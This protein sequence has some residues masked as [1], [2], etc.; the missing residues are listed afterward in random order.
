MA[1]LAVCVACSPTDQAD[2]DKNLAAPDSTGATQSMAGGEDKREAKEAS[3]ESNNSNK[4]TADLAQR[5][6]IA[7]PDSRL[8]VIVEVITAV[9]QVQFEPGKRDA[10][11][12]LRPT[13]VEVKSAEQSEDRF[14]EA[15]AYFEGRDWSGHAPVYIRA[16]GAI[17]V[18][19]T[20]KELKEI[21]TQPFVRKISM[22]QR[23]GP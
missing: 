14:D 7:Q 3:A 15:V 9:P 21:L 5:L 2:G 1:V 20:P 13:S 16:A 23:Y 11:A 8:A 19:V 17:S 4:L 18:D 12:A 6:G 10:G 22:S